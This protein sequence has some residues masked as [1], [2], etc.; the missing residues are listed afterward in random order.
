M[1]L[2]LLTLLAC[3]VDNPAR[4]EIDRQAAAAAVLASPYGCPMH[5]E[6]H[7]TEPGT[8]PSCGMALVKQER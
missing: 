1:R 2:A 8:C 7:A 4:A 3:S 6:V 5:P